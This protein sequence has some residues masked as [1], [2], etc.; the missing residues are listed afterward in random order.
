MSMYVADLETSKINNE[1]WVWA[2]G[3]CE[4]GNIDNFQYG[5]TMDEFMNWCRKGKENKTVY[6]H[7]LRFDGEFIFHYLLTHG[8]TH[9]DKKEENTFNCIISGQGQFYSIEVI[10]KKMSKKVKKV[11]FLDSNKKLPFPV[12]KIGKAFGLEM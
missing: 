11:T 8:F 1:T 9:S 4:I 5:S 6:F 7:N 10:F 2:W 3:F 12:A